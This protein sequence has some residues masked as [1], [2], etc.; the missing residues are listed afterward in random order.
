MGIIKKIVFI[1]F[2]LFTVQTSAQTKQDTIVLK[3][4]M[5]VYHTVKPN[6]TYQTIASKYYVNSLNQVLA[7]HLQLM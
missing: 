2:V 6:E 3:G 7:Q 4:K 1:F 5:Y